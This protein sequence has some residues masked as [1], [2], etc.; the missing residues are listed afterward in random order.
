M[1]N[2]F[3]IVGVIAVVGCNTPADDR[4]VITGEIVVD[5]ADDT[6]QDYIESL[7]KRYN[8]QFKAVS[9]YSS[10]DKVY[11]GEYEG[12]DEDAVIHSIRNDSKVEAA[13]RD[14]IY[15]IPENN[16]PANEEGIVAVSEVGVNSGFPNDPRF[17]EQWHMR[18][19]HLPKSW[20]DSAGKGVIVAV[21]DTG[22]SKTQDLTFTQFIAG[23][24]FVDNNDRP[25]DGNGHGTHVAGTI[26][27]STN[28]SI[29][30]A[31]VAYQ[32]TIMPIK[33]LSDSGSGSLGAIT[34][35]IRFATD[36][37]AKVINMS[38]G[39]GGYNQVMA[40]AIKD[41]HDKGV[42]VVCA[43]GNNGRSSVIYPAAYDNVIAVAATQ[44]NERTTFYS[45]WGKEIAISAPGGNT[46]AGAAG[47]VLQNT[48]IKGKDDYYFLQGSSMSSPHVAGVVALIMAEGINDPNMVRKILIDTARSPEGLKNKPSNYAEHYGAGIVD[49]G[50]AVAKARALVNPDS[51][52]THYVLF[53]ALFLFVLYFG[54]RW[55]G[56]RKGK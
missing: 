40:K 4:D 45:N 50:K 54:Y 28:N 11:V 56:R 35:G 18:Q 3:A 55:Y 6:N 39:G 26:A 36:H 27:Q 42:V 8:I 2:L 46:R 31:G 10:V 44:K 5:F 53:V 48:I 21:I 32:A 23:Y 9:N 41:A 29:G 33:V 17:N 25:V 15:S 14:M 16:L 13:D 30:V 47:G 19:I 52:T 43:A 24:N 1:K 51:K 38:L 34:E 22:V 37:G 20:K 7:G 49:A 12:N